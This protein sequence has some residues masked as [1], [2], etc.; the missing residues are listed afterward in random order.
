MVTSAAAGRRNDGE[1]GDQGGYDG[2]S[3]RPA[4]AFIFDW[5]DRDPKQSPPEM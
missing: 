2:C 5:P 4:H 1:S 3:R